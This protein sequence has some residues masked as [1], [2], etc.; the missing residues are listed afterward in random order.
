MVAV[1]FGDFGTFLVRSLFVFFVVAVIG[2][3]DVE[4]F[5]DF[6]F[7][8]DGLGFGVVNRVV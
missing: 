5:A 3:D 2:V 6:V 7:E 8:V 4:E 1:G